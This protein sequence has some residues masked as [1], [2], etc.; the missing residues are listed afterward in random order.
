MSRSIKLSVKKCMCKHECVCSCSNSELVVVH[1][2][3]QKEID[4]ADAFLA[5]YT[6]TTVC[7]KCVGEKCR[8]E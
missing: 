6:D 4:K 3:N 7:K 5:Y 2:D 1:K 8:D